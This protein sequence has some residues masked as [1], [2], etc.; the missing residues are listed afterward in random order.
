MPKIAKK[1]VAARAAVD[2]TKKYT[3]EEACDI[4]KKSAP[5]KFDETVDIA[6]RLGVNPRHADQM[7]RGAVVLPHGTGQALRVLRLRQG[8]EGEGGGGRRRR[9][10][11]GAEDLVAKVQ[12][13]FMDFDRW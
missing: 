12:E 2:R 11:V 5:A 6:V 9:H 8:R 3:L 10:F 13:G 1:Q 7:V 4:V